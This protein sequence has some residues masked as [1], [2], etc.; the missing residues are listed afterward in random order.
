MIADVRDLLDSYPYLV[1]VCFGLGVSLVLA[2]NDLQER[3]TILRAG[4]IAVPSAFASIFFVPDYWQPARLVTLFETGI[5][6]L[7]FAFAGGAVTWWLAVLPVRT[8]LRRVGDRFWLGRWLLLTAGGLA[9]LVTLLAFGF[10]IMTAALVMIV[11][12]GLGILWK[13]PRLW[14][15]AAA[16]CL[17]FTPIYLAFATSTLAA[18]P[19]AIEQWNHAGLWGIYLWRLPLEELAWAAGYGAV[20][21]LVVAYVFGVT[22][23]QRRP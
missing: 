18:W 8:R 13:R 2:G 10:P 16:G 3:T 12:V 19:L 7:L 21:P 15:L 6:D 11:A 22:L 9:V 23:T 20:W 5:E 14:P 1:A 4:M 17:L